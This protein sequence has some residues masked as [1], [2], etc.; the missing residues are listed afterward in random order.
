MP[1]N[2]EPA[3]TPAGTPPWGADFDAER[4]WALVEGLRSDK[5]TLQAR[6]TSL[7]EELTTATTE[8]DSALAERDTVT[9]ERDTLQTNAAKV[10]RDLLVERVVRKH[11]L[12]ESLAD[13]LSGDTEEELEAKAARLAALGKS[14][15]PA[16]TEDEPQEPTDPVVPGR[17]TPSLTPGH[18]GAPAEP[19]DPAAIAAAVRTVR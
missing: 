15:A 18:G 11:G 10:Q 13:F 1:E 7:S 5:T 9:A 14:Q 2:P 17:P 4:A 12:D 6:V 8:R 19:F 16:P 3:Q